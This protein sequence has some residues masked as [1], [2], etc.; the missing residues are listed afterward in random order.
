MNEKKE[1]E[2]KVPGRKTLPY[3]LE[4]EQCV[5][6]C[7]IK[8][9][10]LAH[11]IIPLLCEED[12][13]APVNRTVFTAVYSVFKSNKTIDFVTVADELSRTGLMASIGGISYLTAIVDIVP[14]TANYNDYLEIVRRDAAMRNLIRECGKIIEDAH[15]AENREK[16]LASAEKTVYD[17]NVSG[18]SKEMTAMSENVGAV[19][20]KLQTIHKNPDA[21]KGVMSG[22]KKLDRITNGFQKGNLI[23]IAGRPG[24]GKSTLAMNIVEHAAVQ[25]GKVCAVFSLEMTKEEIT[26]RTAFSLA[27]ISM[28]KGLGGQLNKETDWHALLNIAHPLIMKSKVF[29]DDNTDITAEEMRSKCRRIKSKNGLDLVM[30]DYIQLMQSK[31]KVENRQQEIANFTRS[32]KLL[33]KEL[34]VPVI[35]LSQVNREGEKNAQLSNLKESG[36]IE[37]DAD[38]VM[39]IDI[40]K[41][42]S[43]RK[44]VEDADIRIAKHRNGETGKVAVKWIREAIKFVDADHPFLS[45]FGDAVY[46]PQGFELPGLETDA[47]K[48]EFTGLEPSPEEEDE[49][50]D[51]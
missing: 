14:G 29:I 47:E 45:R 51:E 22:F 2:K 49:G 24:E 11:E 15:K 9:A 8:D 10:D 19:L 30:V 12:F 44:A 48:T 50:G 7:I 42:D 28:S 26:Q 36:A 46:N 13:Y 34:K 1:K 27:G 16:M 33:A 43:V 32:L 17:L 23:I 31:E 18:D 41:K 6:G 35:A 39:F 20:T 25:T 5:L 40:N 21:L 4:A 38:I 3:N 37:Q